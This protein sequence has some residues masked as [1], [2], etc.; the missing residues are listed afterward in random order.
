MAVSN[1]SKYADRGSRKKSQE[2]KD[3][4]WRRGVEKFFPIVWQ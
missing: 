3:E 2:K 1:R 4:I